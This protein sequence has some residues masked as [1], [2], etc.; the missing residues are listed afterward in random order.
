[1]TL[2]RK[3]CK[4]WRKDVGRKTSK[5][6]KACTPV[7]ND[8]CSS[9][10]VTRVITKNRSSLKKHRAKR[11]VSKK[12]S[13]T[14]V[15]KKSLRRTVPGPG[16]LPVLTV[17]DLQQAAIRNIAKR[18][19]PKSTGD[20]LEDLKN[21]YYLALKSKNPLEKNEVGFL[22]K[23]IAHFNSLLS[24]P[25]GDHDPQAVNWTPQNVYSSKIPKT[26]VNMGTTTEGATSPDPQEQ[27]PPVPSPPAT[28]SFSDPTARLQFGSPDQDVTFI[29]GASSASE[30]SVP[31]KQDPIDLRR[32]MLLS[33]LN[34]EVHIE[35][36]GDTVTIRNKQYPAKFIDLTQEQFEKIIDFMSTLPDQSNRI[37]RAPFKLSHDIFLTF[38]RVITGN[39]VTTPPTHYELRSGLPEDAA[40][41]DNISEATSLLKY[42]LNQVKESVI[43]RTQSTPVQ[44]EELFKESFPVG[45][46]TGYQTYS[47]SPTVPDY[48]SQ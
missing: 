16:S 12:K 14:A 7:N 47:Q 38:I 33:Y 36:N 24:G 21:R 4:L 18:T 17:A 29:P 22:R 37:T 9:R 35:D 45:E 6:K 48:F 41:V 8:L 32:K 11:I 19:V 15:D 42:T 13:I 5:K 20:P 31:G 26:F 1:M 2:R 34:Q 10:G 40:L 30:L 46:D 43:G 44:V 3:G 39:I 28:P 23:E 25:T 27:Q